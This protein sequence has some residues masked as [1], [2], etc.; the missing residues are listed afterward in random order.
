MPYVGLISLGITFK[1]KAAMMINILLLTQDYFK[2]MH[3]FMDAHTSVYPSFSC[4]AITK[5][6]GASPEFARCDDKEDRLT[7]R[8]V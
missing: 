8:V 7:V 5:A 6:L 4:R 2:T 3:K 1:I